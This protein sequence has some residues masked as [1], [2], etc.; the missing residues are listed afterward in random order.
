MNNKTQFLEKVGRQHAQLHGFKD[1]NSATFIM[2]LSMAN[3]R[4][5]LALTIYCSSEIIIEAL[6]RKP[7]GPVAHSCNPATARGTIIFGWQ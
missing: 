7:S 6:H 3:Q 1:K 2:T 5:C 4:Y